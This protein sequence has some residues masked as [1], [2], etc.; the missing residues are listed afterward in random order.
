MPRVIGL[1]S[2][3]AILARRGRPQRRPLSSGAYRALVARRAVAMP[4][5]KE[6]LVKAEQK[7]TGKDAKR[8]IKE[9]EQRM[10]QAA[11]LL[12]GDLKQRRT[13]GGIVCLIVCSDNSPMQQ[14]Q[15]S[16]R[17]WY[18]SLVFLAWSKP[19]C[20]KGAAFH[21]MFYSFPTFSELYY[22]CNQRAL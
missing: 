13:A 7:I 14:R 4:F 5:K 1:V 18:G 10:P 8:L 12:S 19:C 11:K 9:A 15:T 2:S 6:L 20:L 21:Y 3:L 22:W 16:Q 17:C